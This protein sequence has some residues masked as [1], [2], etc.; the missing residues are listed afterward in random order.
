MEAALFK[1]EED[2]FETEERKRE[3]IRRIGDLRFLK[4]VSRSQEELRKTTTKATGC[5]KKKEE[6]DS[7]ALPMLWQCVN[8][9]LMFFPAEPN[10]PIK[11][12]R[13][14]QSFNVNCCTLPLV[15]ETGKIFPSFQ[16]SI[17]PE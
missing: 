7:T 12:F 5:L 2:N 17:F 4:E 14:R 9:L 3:S 1:D 15:F 6:K 8:Q 13:Y 10:T 11:E 16:Y